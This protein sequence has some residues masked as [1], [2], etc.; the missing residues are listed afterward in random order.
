MVRFEILKLESANLKSLTEE[1]TRK[2]IPVWV[3]EDERKQAMGKK[4]SMLNK[5]YQK[6]P[7]MS[8]FNLFG[9]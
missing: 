4:K 2:R 1:I 9:R 7:T 3:I 5:I 6:L 8:G